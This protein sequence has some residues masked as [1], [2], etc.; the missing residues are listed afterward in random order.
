MAVKDKDVE[1]KVDEKVDYKVIG[2]RP[3]R[4]DATDKI[5][6]R[7]LYGGDFHAAGLLHGKVLRSPHAHARIRSIDKS[8]AEAHPG[9]MAV[10]T[11]EDLPVPED[12]ISDVGEGGTAN[13]KYLSS[14]VLARGKVVYEGH[15]VAAVAAVDVHVAEEALELIDVDYEVLPPVMD[16]LGAMKDDSPI[17]H[18]DLRTKSL[19]EETDKTS[20]IGEYVQHTMGDL[21]KG[22]A[23]AD[24]VVEREFHTAT[25]HQGYIE[26]QNASAHWTLDGRLTIWTS[27]QGAFAVRGEVS[28]ILQLPVSKIKV[29]P[30]EIGGGFG[31]K[32]SVYLDPVAAILS[33]KTGRPVKMVMAREEVLKAT[34]PTPGSYIRVK[35]GAKKDGTI[36]AAEAWMAYEA[37]GFPGGVL[38]PGVQCIFG[39]Y[40]IANVKIDGYD[41]VVN[42]PKT[43]AYRAP[44]ATNAEFASETVVDELAEKLGTDPMELRLKSAAKEGTRRADGPV[45]PRIGCIETAQ[46][47]KDHEHYS[48][49]LEGANRG[50]GVATGFW[51]NVGLQS[52]CSMSVNSDGTV[53]MVSG[54]TD[55]AGTRT[56][57]SMQAAEVLGIPVEDFIPSVGDTDSVGYTDVTGGSRVTFATGW[58]VYEAARDVKKQM[59]ERA[60][61]IWDVPVDQVTHS[62]G[63]FSAKSDTSLKFTFKELADKLS[64]TGGTVI[65]SASV[66]PKGIGGAF[67]THIVDVEVDP[68]TGKVDILRYT[69]VQDVGKAIH[70]SYVEGQIQGGAVQGIGW[71]LNE[72]YFYNEEGKLANASLLDYRMPTA[73]DLPMI[74][75]VLVEVANP[76]H[77][78][79]VRGVGEV[80]I[81]PPP[82]AIANAIYNAIGVRMTNLP[83]S[84]GHVLETLWKNGK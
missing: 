69:A 45:Y 43:N 48:A 38:G 44:G 32:I 75:A 63:V 22:F 84:P 12:K 70:P 19:G 34:G 28:D 49:P 7:A 64:D 54:S 66:D 42:K 27:T 78:F 56:A 77:P 58:A 6:G 67:A 83:M 81:V 80:P 79:G 53:S 10:V 82:A 16:V 60:A 11:S 65:G 39:P 68:E 18:D 36:T 76:G 59:K 1:T 72:E 20:N 24:V 35:M 14:N 8:R 23:E 73:L 41:V 71:A 29:V 15:A 37:G 30:M 13:V 52:S 21:E 33:R 55:L 2:S 62:D 17:L 61:L 5:T 40:N 51:F 31:G 50:R 4:H 26:P 57:L 47:A 9:V 74:E 46:A 25:V 3:I